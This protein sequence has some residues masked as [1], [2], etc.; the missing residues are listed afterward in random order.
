MYDIHVMNGSQYRIANVS[1]CANNL[2]VVVNK[3]EMFVT[4]YVRVRALTAAGF[5]PWSGDVIVT[6]NQT[7]MTPLNLKKGFIRLYHTRVIYAQ[8]VMRV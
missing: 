2:S 3:L 7:G 5:G 4:Y 8:S 1:V 6:T